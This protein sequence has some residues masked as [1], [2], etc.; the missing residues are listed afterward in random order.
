VAICDRLPGVVFAAISL[1][2]DEVLEPSPVLATVED[3][4]HFPLLFS[5]NKYRWRVSIWFM[6]WY[7]V[8][9]SGRQ[10]DAIEDRIK[11]SH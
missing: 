4:F 10:F 2:L 9:Q 7:W 8:L 11:L 5:I 3:L 1:P 6:A